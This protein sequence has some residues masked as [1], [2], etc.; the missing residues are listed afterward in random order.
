MQR[1]GHDLPDDF[2]VERLR[3]IE[4][5]ERTREAEAAEADAAMLLARTRSLPDTLRDFSVG[6]VRIAVEVHGQRFAG[7]VAHVA[8]DFFVLDSGEAIAAVPMHAVQVIRPLEAGRGVLPITAARSW[9]ALLL[10]LEGRHVRMLLDGAEIDGM[11]VAA[12]HDHVVVEGVDGRVVIPHP[13]IHGTL[14][15]RS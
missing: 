9:R 14:W 6:S 12:A 8:A 1:S 7:S 15:R 2:T 10:E 4:R 5:D 11:L 13:A 3:Q